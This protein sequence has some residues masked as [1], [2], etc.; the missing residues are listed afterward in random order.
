MSND[1]NAITAPEME[2]DSSLAFSRTNPQHYAQIPSNELTPPHNQPQVGGTDIHSLRGRVDYI[3]K[4]PL[5]DKV[6]IVVILANSILMACSDYTHVDSEGNLAARGSRINTAI[7]QSDVAFTILFTVEFVLKLI[8]F[9]VS[10][11]MDQWNNFDFFIVIISWVSLGPNIPAVKVLRTLRVLRPLKSIKSYPALAD[12]VNSVLNALV[13][14]RSFAVIF[15]C[16]LLIFGILGLQL[17]SGPYLH[18]RCRLTPFP[19]NT[20]W[21]PGDDFDLYRCTASPTFNVPEDDLSLTKSSSPWHTPLVGCF[22]PVDAAD[23]ARLCSL[24]GDGTHICVH[25][26]DRVPLD[27]WRWCKCC[28]C[29]A[30]L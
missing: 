3:V 28:C 24:T 5:F 26:D 20:S 21:L 11:F 6:S 22:W 7:S 23:N 25:G 27:R 4:H 14:L 29:V 1:K 10:Y 8:A 30:C 2:L 17:F 18:A 9:G 15:V 19:V 16:F 12:M 13:R